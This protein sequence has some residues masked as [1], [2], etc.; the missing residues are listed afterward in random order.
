MQP[1]VAKVQAF[2]RQLPQPFLKLAVFS[3]AQ[4]PI[5]AL[6][7]EGLFSDHRLQHA[8]VHAQIR[9][10]LLQSRALIAKVLDLFGFAHFHAAVLR[11]SGM[12]RALAH[13]LFQ[14]NIL[15]RAHRL[16][17]LQRSDNPR[18]RAPALAHRPFSFLRRNRIPKWT[19]LDGKFSAAGRGTTDNTSIFRKDLA[20][21]AD[22]VSD[23]N[24]ALAIEPPTCMRNPV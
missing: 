18:P 21:T 7:T 13:T 1:P 22:E 9:D 6:L 24:T 3:S 8:L 2:S 5:A 11:V 12:D 20:R 15:G 14:R 16:H 10:Q 4:K 19:D 23:G 17:L